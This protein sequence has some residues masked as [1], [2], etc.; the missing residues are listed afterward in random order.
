MSGIV[1]QQGTSGDSGSVSADVSSYNFIGMIQPFGM[2]AAPNGWVICN[3][4]AISRTTYA[5]LFTVIGT[6]WGSGDGS[7]TFNVPRLQGAFLRGAGSHTSQMGNTN[8]FAGGNIGTIDN[9]KVQ[10]FQLASQS[11]ILK[12][13]GPDTGW[14]FIGRTMGNHGMAFR[15]GTFYYDHTQGGNSP[16][17]GQIN[18][19]TSMGDAGGT[20][21]TS[22]GTRRAGGESKPFSA[23]VEYMIFSG[24]TV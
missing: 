24:V 6:T 8:V 9:D 22:G 23:A 5:D 19:T 13:G 11:G 3:G 14:G 12:I 4:A 15:T 7:S 10:D 17:S 16:Y 20:G 21:T 2:A 18:T 1:K